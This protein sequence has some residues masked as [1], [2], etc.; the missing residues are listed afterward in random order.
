[1]ETL[2]ITRGTALFKENDRVYKYLH[3]LPSEYVPI[4]CESE[5]LI[6]SPDLSHQTKKTTP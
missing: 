2:N 1:M 3:E 5:K 4:T 6:T